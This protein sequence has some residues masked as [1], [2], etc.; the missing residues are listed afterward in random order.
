MPIQRIDLSDPALGVSFSSCVVAGDFVF[1]SHTS[2]YDRENNRWPETIEEQT[3]QC[4]LNLKRILASANVALDV[5]VKVTLLLKRAEDF[6]RIKDVYRRQFTE[7]YPAR[8]GVITE[9]LDPECLIQL[10]AVAY[11]PR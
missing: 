11:K 1:T 7:G 8:T 4:C 9:F 2:G 6:R 5:V 3:A 10:D